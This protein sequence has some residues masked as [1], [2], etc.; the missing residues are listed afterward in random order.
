MI[1]YFTLDF[2][3]VL[4]LTSERLAGNGIFFPS[5]ESSVHR[6][7]KVNAVVVLIVAALFYELFMF[8]RRDAALSK[9]I[10]FGNDPCDAVVASR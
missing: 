8:P 3:K 7:V 1:E 2:D 5:M 4:R 10:P 9:V 6:T